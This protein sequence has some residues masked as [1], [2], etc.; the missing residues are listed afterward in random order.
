[1]LLNPLSQNFLIWFPNNFFYPEVESIWL[2]MV[3]R[4]ALPYRTIED[5]I[6]SQITSVNMPGYNDQTVN[7][8]KGLYTTSKRSG[9]MLDQ[10]MEKKL[11]V[12]IKLTESYLTWFIWRAQFEAFLNMGQ[13]VKGLFMPPVHMSMLDNE[14]FEVASVVLSDISL[15][16]IGDLQLSYAAKVGQYTDFS[17]GFT[18]NYIDF[19]Y[20]IDR[21]NEAAEVFKSLY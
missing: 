10:K 18:Y 2:P 6:N 17:L 13:N 5:F 19:D 4:M 15:Q 11:T 1:M 3:R 8:Q 12:Q 14:G 9:F 16:S 20:R 21:G 7:Q